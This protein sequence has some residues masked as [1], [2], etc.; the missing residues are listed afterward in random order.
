MEAE[1]LE[2]QGL[3]GQAVFETLEASGDYSPALLSALKATQLEQ[4]EA[5]TRIEIPVAAL[6]GGM[7]L[8]QDVVTSRQVLIAPRGCEV[9]P[10]FLEHLRHFA[11]QLPPKIAVLLSTAAAE[12]QESPGRGAALAQ[13]S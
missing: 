7:I 1:R 13:T 5:L 8:D 12:D 9:T 4:S 11:K 6:A 10:S 3:R 2:V